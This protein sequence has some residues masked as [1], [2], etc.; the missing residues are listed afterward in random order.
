[1]RL[2]ANVAVEARYSSC[3]AH[4]N[5]AES[6]RASRSPT[7]SV[8]PGSIR[9]KGRGKTCG[10]SVC[11][12]GIQNRHGEG[13]AWEDRRGNVT[14]GKDELLCATCH[15]TLGSGL[16]RDAAHWLDKYRAASTVGLPVAVVDSFLPS[17]ACLCSKADY[18]Y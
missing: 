5:R 13:G 15:R 7:V 17:T 9:C 1:M 18:F 16:R 10:L 14:H 3:P 12:S 11:G 8:P 4:R 6:R 2:R